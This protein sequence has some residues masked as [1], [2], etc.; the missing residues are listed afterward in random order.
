MSRRR[1]PRREPQSGGAYA[2]PGRIPSGDEERRREQR[3]DSYRRGRDHLIMPRVIVGE[4]EINLLIGLK[5]LHADEAHDAAAV[6]R[7]IG[8]LL[9]E[10]ARK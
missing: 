10:M 6:G 9:R 3:R 5:H 7:A 2:T 4:A 1:P 8:A